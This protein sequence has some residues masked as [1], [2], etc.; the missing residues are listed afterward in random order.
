LQDGA[1]S[2]AAQAQALGG[3]GTVQLSTG[4]PSVALHIPSLLA[5]KKRS[6][7]GGKESNLQ[8]Q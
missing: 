6:K 8:T 1:E 7:T 2:P 4:T 3:D 5:K